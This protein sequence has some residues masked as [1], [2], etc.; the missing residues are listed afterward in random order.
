MTKQELLD[1]TII[2]EERQVPF[3]EVEIHEHAHVKIEHDDEE[4]KV[5]VKPE[6]E[7]SLQPTVK[8]EQEDEKTSP[9]FASGEPQIKKEQEDEG[10]IDLAAKHGTDKTNLDKEAADIEDLVT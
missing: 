7:G 9:F 8:K 3:G 1:E 5:K 6:V 10:I 2:K 4:T